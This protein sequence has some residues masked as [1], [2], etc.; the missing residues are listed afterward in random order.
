M[1]CE[2]LKQKVW[3]KFG[4][5]EYGVVIA[6]ILNW[7]ILVEVEYIV[8][9]NWCLHWWDKVLVNRQAALYAL[10]YSECGGYYYINI[11]LTQFGKTYISSKF[12]CVSG[13]H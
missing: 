12:S 13:G 5:V 11:N 2:L 6:D 10:Q 8:I 9:G 3:D 4:G 1:I 7:D